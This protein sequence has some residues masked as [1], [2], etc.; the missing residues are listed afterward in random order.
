MKKKLSERFLKKLRSRQELCDVL[1]ISY[2]TLGR[3]IDNKLIN[4]P[5]K[6]A[7][8]RWFYSESVFQEAIIQYKKVQKELENK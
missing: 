5:D 3:Y 1:G 8:T 7:K 4:A 6:Q 2:N